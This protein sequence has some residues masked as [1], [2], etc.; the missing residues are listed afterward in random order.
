MR[1]K[2]WTLLVVA[3]LVAFTL[4]WVTPQARAVFIADP[5]PPPPPAPAP[6]PIPEPVPTPGPTPSPPTH[7]TPEPATLLSGL[8]GGGVLSLVAYRKRRRAAQLAVDEERLN[9]PKE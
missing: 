9:Q 2:N 3:G 5:G 6:T 8:I 7:D 1:S 4:A